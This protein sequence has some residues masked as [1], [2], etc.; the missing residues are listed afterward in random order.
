MATDSTPI[1]ALYV[2]AAA[3][4][5]AVIAGIGWYNAQWQNG[6]LRDAN[7]NFVAASLAV[8]GALAERLQNNDASVKRI[9]G[10]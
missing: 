9:L 2:L 10:G 7:A 6:A 1:R 8:Q 5:V 3:V 4:L